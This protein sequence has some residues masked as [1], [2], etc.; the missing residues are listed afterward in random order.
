MGYIY[1]NLKHY[2]NID[3][4]VSS[5]NNDF[6]PERSFGFN[7]L[8]NLERFFVVG[9]PGFGKTRLLKELVIS[10]A[11]K[12]IE[13]IFID[14]K[15][16][17][18]DE[19]IEQYID[20]SN[21]EIYSNISSI[22]EIKNFKSDS[23]RLQ[24]SNN[25]LICFDALDEVS[26]ENFSS[27]VFQISEFIEKFSKVKIAISCRSN[28]IN[29]WRD[30]LLDFGIE[31]TKIINFDYEQI[32]A[33]LNDHGISKEYLDKIADNVKFRERGLIIQTPR[34]LEI[35]ANMTESINL[36][37]LLE[38]SRGEL[39]EKIIY[40]KLDIE[41]KK[42]DKKSNKNEVIRMVLEKLALIME[43][44]QSNTI[45]KE[46]VMIFF[47]DIKSNLSIS[48]LNQVS[49]TDLYERRL[50]KDNIDSLEFEHTE[51]QEYL[52]AK[53][54]LRLGRMDQIVF[55]LI[56]NKDT[57]EINPSWLNTLTFLIELDIS[58]LKNILDF[59]SNK[60]LVYNEDH[61]KLL[62][63]FNANRLTDAQ[64][65]EIFETVFIYHQEVSHWIDFDVAKNLS[66]F[67]TND[68]YK[69]IEE[70]YKNDDEVIKTNCVL[71]LTYL[72]DRNVLNE[73]QLNFWK[74]EFVKNLNGKEGNE[75]LQRKSITALG[76]YRDIELLNKVKSN[77]FKFGKETVV[78]NLVYAYEEVDKNSISAVA[79]FVDGSKINNI[80]SRIA[81]YDISNKEGIVYI[82]NSF[83][84]DKRWLNEFIEHESIYNDKSKNILENISDIV[85]RK[86]ILKIKK[87]ILMAF[88][89]E[90][91]Y[92]SQSSV[93][94]KG[95]VEIVSNFEKRYILNLLK[96]VK[97]SE[98]ANGRLFSFEQI[99]VTILKQE[100][101][102]EFVE[103]FKAIGGPDWQ[104]MRIMNSIKI[105]K[106]LEGAKIYE[107]GRKFLLDEYKKNE[108]KLPKKPS[109]EQILY[110]EFK[111]RLEPAS[112][113]YRQDVFRFYLDNKDKIGNLITDEDR[114]RMKKLI[115]ESIFDKFDPGKQKLK[116][117]SRSNGSMNYTT[118]SW[119]FI[120]G[121]CLRIAH[122][123]KISVIKYR[124][125]ILN[126]IPFAHD[127]ALRAIF[128]LVPNPTSKELTQVLKIYTNKK[129]GDL[130]EYQ[131]SSLITATENYRLHK[132][133]PILKNFVDNINFSEYDRVSAL[134]TIGVLY[135]KK[136]YFN[137]V[138]KKYKKNKG[139]NSQIAATANE[140]LI[141]LDDVNA[142]KWR[143]TELKKRAFPFERAEGAH[144][145]GVGEMEL[146]DKL[147]ARPIINLNN[148]RYKNLFL[149]L[150]KESFIIY[151]KDKS[152]YSYSNYLWDIVIQYYKNLKENNTYSYLKDLEKFIINNS[153]KPGINWFRY[154]F[155]NLKQEYIEYLG[156]PKNIA[157]CIKKYNQLK[158][159]I[160]LDIATKRDLFEFVKNIF[161]IDL[162]K[163]VESEG[164]YKFIIE[165][166]RKQED[167]IQKTIN[168]QIE[169]CLLKGGL[170][171]EE[172]SIKRESQL[173][174]N[175]RTDFLVSYG[176]VGSI[177]IEIKLATNKEL[178]GPKNRSN[179]RKK[180]IQYISGTGSDY[181]I[182]VIFNNDEK[183]SHDDFSSILS[184]IEKTYVN[185][186]YISIIGL[187]CNQR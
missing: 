40:H 175:K 157:D 115:V 24:N 140:C 56:V 1:P 84:K 47:D 121:D 117:N 130:H 144:N 90:I 161:E 158:G 51:F 106:K 20:S 133:V 148:E 71:V 172:I 16:L 135:N 55:D 118:H 174:D 39:L 87:I 59:Y 169:N 68:L 19:S 125:N 77:V 119:I 50:L 72:I 80:S 151:L 104:L 73:R 2:K 173:L 184:N 142:I 69:V 176:F 166:G 108:V 66:Y 136:E 4:L 182:F 94:I 8:L 43:I 132:A 98:D 111:T 46:E 62:P 181:G 109:D 37:D 96:S 48:F 29:R 76:K 81:L 149:D 110:K 67:Y 129:N 156:K 123:F 3:D 152:Y 42:G 79:C 53:E 160:Y 159:M 107:E 100:Q 26:N 31:Y 45:S 38:M 95:L 88:E 25:V 78:S 61:F 187:D 145:V 14:L 185:D 12:G 63:R 27:V 164:A 60:D 186:R 99:F 91:W 179:Y 124:Q 137:T 18:K 114:K 65:K 112:G 134:K 168:S 21:I 54:I 155:Q 92:K 83:I 52:A 49:I 36:D 32:A 85:D 147:F 170:R 139:G 154:K 178:S 162:R 146:D 143:F 75:V 138:W 28:Y 141:A 122:D 167:L 15:R 58:L 105:S 163:W 41:T 126:Y 11:E 177:L 17:R 102:K 97:T 57:Q 89:P 34:Y 183:N 7:N 82:I 13:G 127:K 165:A 101:V 6:F 74:N 93:F 5:P 30:L 23:F 171:K 44:R 35:L 9:E 150:L 131:P 180:L 128:D 113:M 22:S 120:F 103:L 70:Y 64:K 153:K 116:I 10:S 86:L 33:Y